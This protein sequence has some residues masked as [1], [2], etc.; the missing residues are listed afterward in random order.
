ML[1]TLILYLT[2]KFETFNY[3]QKVYG[4]G[5]A[6]EI[7]ESKLISVYDGNTEQ[8]LNLD[9]HESLSVFLAN[10]NK[11]VEQIESEVVANEY[12][13]KHTYPFKC[14]IYAKSN[15]NVNCAS[16]SRLIAD[17]IEKSITGRQKALLAS[18]QL[19]NAYIE[20][21][22]TTL[23]KHTLYA[24][25]FTGGGLGDNDILIEIEFD[26]IVEGNQNCFVD[27]P[28]DNDEFVFNFEQPQSFCEKVDECLDI[29]TEDGQYVL[30]ITD[31]V[32]SWAEYSP[33]GAVVISKTQAQFFALVSSSSLDFPAVYKITDIQNGLYIDTL[34][35]S[36]FS[37][38]ATL[39][40][41]APDYTLHAQYHSSDGAIADGAIVTWGGYYWENVSGGA[42][43]PDLPDEVDIDSNGA[44]FS[45]ISKSVVN[46]YVAIV[47]NA[48]IDT[49]LV[50][51]KVID[52]YNNSI[53]IKSDDYTYT[54]VGYENYQWN[55][56]SNGFYNNQAF[57][58][59][60]VLATGGKILSNQT[61]S[62]T[63]IVRNKVDATSGIVKNSGLGNDLQVSE[64]RNC[65]V[66]NVG[67][68]AGNE[69]HLSAIKNTT[70]DGAGSGAAIDECHL[71]N[72][73]FIEDC[74]ITASDCYFASCWF[75]RESG[76]RNVNLTVTSSALNCVELYD[77]T[78]IED[79]APT[80]AIQSTSI[81]C[82]SDLD[83]TGFDREFHGNLEN[84]KG[85]FAITHDFTTSPLNSGSSVLYNL[86]PQGAI[87]TGLIAS[88][89]LTGTT[90]EIGLET[91]A[92]G[93]INEAVGLLPLEWSGVSSAATANRSLK[94]KA[95]GGNITAGT[96]TVKVEFTV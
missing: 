76:L 60:N 2:Q 41:L 18:T 26:F 70:V 89:S 48:I 19:V 71:T 77:Q 66:S 31:G 6:R 47:L 12:H 92:E 51:T 53:E 45:R 82:N 52:Q 5:V 46:G 17:S 23:E 86:I 8:H 42:V 50:V 36:T 49:S 39:S 69:L 37:P 96:L 62:G 94:I 1:S 85:W 68:I 72:L 32:K 65:V 80:V 34:S 9:T 24:N 88:G 83:L 63:F 3:L 93:L 43:T 55:L 10:G 79:Y 14:I 7:N 74:S 25:Y 33:S 78:I 38:S 30:D 75:D 81:T 13:V 22:N 27:S 15:E 95:A 35:A 54:A 87:I 16:K 59:N 11:T 61:V 73:S 21:K 57:I 20:V 64:I 84:G 67:F 90:I 58:S 4:L 28:C 56:S 29:P 91:D 44:L 40:F